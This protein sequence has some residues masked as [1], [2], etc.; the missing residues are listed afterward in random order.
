MERLK[1]SHQK[2]K[3][4]KKNLYLWNGD[5]KVGSHILMVKIFFSR[6]NYRLLCLIKFPYFMDT[7]KRGV[8]GWREAQRWGELMD[9]SYKLHYFIRGKLVP[10]PNYASLKIMCMGGCFK[11]QS[12]F[13]PIIWENYCIIK[14]P[15]MF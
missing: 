10:T 1:F 11:R 9:F 14:V 12:I 7:T 6:T 15:Y 3:N 4:L 8:R 13:Q 5:S 2:Y